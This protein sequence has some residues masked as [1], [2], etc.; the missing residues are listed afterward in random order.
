MQKGKQL[1]QNDPRRHSKNLRQMLTETIDHALRGVADVSDPKAQA[2]FETTAEVL[3]G[4][5][6]AFED[7]ERRN[8]QAWKQ[9]S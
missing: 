4:I 3:I 6:K 2:L 5:R 8:E 1:S 7:F 9:A